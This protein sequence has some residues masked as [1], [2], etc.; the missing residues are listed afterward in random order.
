MSVVVYLNIAASVMNIVEMALLGLNSESKVTNLQ[1]PK[2]EFSF[3]P[4]GMYHG[5]ESFNG[6]NK[7][8]SH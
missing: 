2:R 7:Q 4:M 8:S 3:I 6:N 5:K 1:F